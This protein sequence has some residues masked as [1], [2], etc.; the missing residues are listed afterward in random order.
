[1]SAIEELAGVVTSNGSYI[2]TVTAEIIAAS[3]LAAGY[4][5]PR[6]ITTA[7][8]LDALPVGSVILSNGGEDS[9]QK[10]DEG[11]WYLWG[12]DIGLVS[13]EIMLPATVL[14]TPEES[15]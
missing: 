3:I 15:K 5:K 11:Y 9:A 14:Y 10:D 4:S 2:G 6:T 13:E 7:E 1:M 12:G 8:E